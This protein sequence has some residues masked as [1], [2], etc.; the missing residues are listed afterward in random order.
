MDETLTSSVFAP[1][2]G[3]LKGV[4]VLDFCSFINGAY[5]AMMM[6]DL[7]AEVIKI[8]PLTGDPARAW[9]PFLKGESRFYQA[10][11]RNKRCLALNLTSLSGREII[12]DLTANAD[13]VLENFRPGVTEKLKIDYLSLQRINPR[14]IYCSSTAFGAAG[15]YRDRP[16]YDPVLQSLSGVARD[17]LRFGGKVTI[18]PVAVSD[19][20]AS[21]LALSAIN[22]ALYH[23]EKTGEG[24]RIETSLL[25]GIMS[26]HAHHFVEPLDCE[27][28]GALGI[29]PYRFF[30]TRDDLIFIAAG[31]DKFW[32][33]LCEAIG[34]AE[35]GANQKYSTNGQRAEHRDELTAMLNDY[36]PLKTTEE[37]EALLIEKGVPCASAKSYRE[38]FAD[39]Q[40][41]A[42]EMNPIIEHPL[43]G[44]LRMA[45]V[46]FRF[47]K[48]PGSVQR[49]APLLGQHTDEILR[50]LGYDEENIAQMRKDGIIA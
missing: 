8:E 18:C 7:G 27:E 10:W 13:V 21:M 45:G 14:I 9:G 49:P 24:Q 40:V 22:A 5:S 30:E 6:G 46:P 29:Y 41:T 25:H 32:R 37:W 36:F 17:N 34:A 3:P 43:I 38:F 35:L 16:G 28:E 2:S 15:P 20:Q 33:M 11:N 12:Y 42:M 4:K 50:G 31:T 48:T 26:I 1:P 44:R 19:Y 47:E 23:R 39:P